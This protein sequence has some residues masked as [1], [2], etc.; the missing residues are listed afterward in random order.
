MTR[1]RA[2]DDETHARL[3]DD[4]SIDGLDP[5]LRERLGRQWA[6][7]ATAELRVASIFASVSAGLLESGADPAVLR[8]AAR[9]VSDEVRHAEICRHV[10]ERY[11]GRE[12]EWPAPGRGSMPSLARAPGSL[13]A[14]LHTIAMGCI[15]ETIA[16]AW[17]ETSLRDATAPL[18]RAAIRE[19]MADDIHHARLGWA[20]LASTFVGPE[21]RRAIGAWLPA[22]F[23]AAAR[24]WT[25]EHPDKVAEGCAEH[26]VPSNAQTRAV[27]RE[28][29]SGVV[30]PGFESL[31]VPIDAGRVWVDR[32]A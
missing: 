6:S 19:L 4:P 26:G 20:H 15:N 31:G 16:S 30:L 3:P 13:K 5:S 7:R 10:A 9:A 2:T 8:I 25:R 22:L 17:L 27:V 12:V 1:L 14:T 18:A 24:P 23:D 11:L 21:A 29:L 28:T 32:E